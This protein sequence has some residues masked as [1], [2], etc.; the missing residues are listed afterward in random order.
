M[1]AVD[2]AI[3]EAVLLGTVGGL[4]SVQI[5]LRRLP[6]FTLAMTHATFPGV[7]LAAITGVDLYAGG[8]LFGVLVVLGVLAL[9]RRPEQGT[10]TA[11]GIVLSAGFALGVVLLSARDGFSKDLTAYTVGQILTVGTGDLTAV[12]VVGVIVV[13]LLS[14]AGRQLTF[15]AFDPGGYAAA[16]YRPA[17][18]DMALLLTVEA[19]IIVAVPAV[20]AIL[21]VAVLVAPAAIARLWTHDVT[22]MTA[23]A[24]ASG[25]GSGLAGV[26]ISTRYDVATGGT[27]TV[28]TGTLFALSLAATTTWTAVAGSRRGRRPVADQPVPAATGPS[29][30]EEAG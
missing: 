27:I 20:G 25:I 22:A 9:S 5:L 18:I 15:R 26:L 21:A 23:I 4:I 19:V 11:I 16:G 6:F 14:V 30:L 1:T 7:V 10:T 2:R 17:V 24:V 8:G 3:L 13:A 12:A 28:V 29:H